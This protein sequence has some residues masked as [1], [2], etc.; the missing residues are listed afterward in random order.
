[1]KKEGVINKKRLTEK[2]MVK[3][4]FSRKKACDVVETIFSSIATELIVGNKVKVVGF[5]AFEVRERAAKKGRNL[6]TGELIDLPPTKAV[7]F[8]GSKKLKKAIKI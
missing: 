7:Q 3:Y 2:L 8:T 6:Q 1:M 5:G 4:E